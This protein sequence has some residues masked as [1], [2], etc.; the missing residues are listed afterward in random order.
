[1]KLFKCLCIQNQE[2]KFKLL[3]KKLD[4]LTKKQTAEL[5]N[6]HVNSEADHPVS[7]TE[8]GL[9]GP[10]VRRRSGRQIKIFNQ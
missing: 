2:R 4:E 7:L 5:S 10:N 6:R 9:D 1:M 3:W 8:V